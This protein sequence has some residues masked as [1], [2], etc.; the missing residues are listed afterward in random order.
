MEAYRKKEED[1][2]KNKEGIQAED[3]KREGEFEIEKGK[4]NEG[5]SI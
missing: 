2:K 5:R 4:E 1:M 3:V